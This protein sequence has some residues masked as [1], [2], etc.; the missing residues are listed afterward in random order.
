MMLNW[1]CWD[2]NWTFFR[3]FLKIVC[4]TY[5]SIMRSFKSQLR[6]HLELVP[7]QNIVE[8][9]VLRKKSC[10]FFCKF[11]SEHKLL[12]SFFFYL[13]RSSTPVET[14]YLYPCCHSLLMHYASCISMLILHTMHDEWSIMR[15]STIAM[16]VSKGS[17]QQA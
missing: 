7:E 11:L 10:N 5:G 6:H 9:K 16:L 2:F 3:L 4:A 13:H 1:V 14:M 8:R 12:V 15:Y 17:S